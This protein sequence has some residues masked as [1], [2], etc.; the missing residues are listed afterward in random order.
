MANNNMRFNV[1]FNVDR[2]GLNAIKTE[3]QQIQNLS[4]Q[5]VIKAGGTQQAVNDLAKIKAHAQQLETALTKAFNPQLNT[6]NLKA[7]KQEL[8]NL[9]LNKLQQ[10]FYSL[11]T[12]GKNAFRSI[13]IDLL[14]Q[15]KYLKQSNTLLTKMRETMAN[16]VRWSITSTIINSITTSIRKAYSY[17]RDLDESLTNI[18]MVTEKSADSMKRFAKEANRAAKELG[19]STKAYTEASLIYYQQGLSDAEVKARTETTIKAANVTGQAAATVS[20]QLTA[21][22]NGY[23][24][25]TKETETYIDKLSAV[26]ASTAADL[27]ELSI[28]MSRVASAANIMGVD[29]DQLNAQLAT[30]VSVTREA[31]ESIGTALKTVYARMSDIEAGLDGET[32]LGEYTTEM[33][34]LGINALDSEGKLRN[35]GAVVE[36]IGNK[37]QSLTREQQTALAQTIAGTRQYSRMMALFDNWEMYEQAMSTS[38]NATGT[39]AAQQAIYMDSLEGRLHEMKAASE[40]VFDSLFDT[41]T[42][43]EIVDD[44][45]DLLEAVEY[46]ID[47][48]GGMKG[49]IMGVSA[50]LTGLFHGQIVSGL[51]QFANNIMGVRLNLENTALAMGMFVKSLDRTQDPRFAE[52]MRMEESLIANRKLLTKEEFAAGQELLSQ[53]ETLHRHTDELE[54]QK[55]KLQEQRA[56]LLDKEQTN[57]SKSVAASG[58]GMSVQFDSATGAIANLDQLSKALTTVSKDETELKN[59]ADIIG[60]AFNDLG[61]KTAGVKS[62]QDEYRE[63]VNKALTPMYELETSLRQIAQNMSAI[64]PKASQEI[65]ALA[66]SISKLESTGNNASAT[67]L[68]IYNRLKTL[69]GDQATSREKLLELLNQY[70]TKLDETNSKEKANNTELD[71]TEQKIKSISQVMDTIMKNMNMRA[72]L[73]QLVTSVTL[74]Q[75]LYF[76]VYSVI[77]LIENWNVDDGRSTFAKLMQFVVAFLPMIINI[78]STIKRMQVVTNEAAKKEAVA[79]KTAENEKQTAIKNTEITSTNTTSII[80]ANEKKV[81]TEA[82]KTAQAIKEQADAYNEVAAAASASQGART[83]GVA[84]S[85]GTSGSLAAINTTMPAGQKVY[86]PGWSPNQEARLANLTRLSTDTNHKKNWNSYT[87]EIAN[88]ETKK[89]QAYK[90]YM[91]TPVPASAPISESNTD[92]VKPLSSGNT[93]P[94]SGSGAKAMLSGIGMTV[95]ISAI[96]TLFTH[97]VSVVIDGFDKMAEQANRGQL[98][99]EATAQA[100]KHYNAELNTAISRQKDMAQDFDA[101]KEMQENLE[102]MTKGTEEYNKALQE[103]NAQVL[104]LVEKYSELSNYLTYE[105]GQY[106]IAEEGLRTAEAKQNNEIKEQASY[107]Q[108]SQMRQKQA[109]IDAVAREQGNAMNIRAWEESAHVGGAV[110]GTVGAS[111]GAIFGTV[112]GTAVTSAISAAASGA[113]AGAVAG[114]WGVVAGILVGLATATVTTIAAIHETQEE[115]ERLSVENQET[116]KEL[117]QKLKPSD[118]AAIMGANDEIT[119]TADEHFSER[120]SEVLKQMG[121]SDAEI[122]RLIKE[123]SENRGALKEVVDAYQQQR[124]M[125][126][127]WLSTAFNRSGEGGVYADALA[128]SYGLDAGELYLTAQSNIEDIYGQGSESNKGKTE[129]VALAYLKAIGKLDG[130]ATLADAKALYKL[131]ASERNFTITIDGQEQSLTKTDAMTV[132]IEEEMRALTQDIMHLVHTTTRELDIVFDKA[133]ISTDTRSQVV[134]ALATGTIIDFSDIAFDELV[135]LLQADQETELTLVDEIAGLLGDSNTSAKEA[136][137]AAAQAANQRFDRLLDYEQKMSANEYELYS[138]YIDGHDEIQSIFENQSSADAGAGADL[139]KTLQSISATGTVDEVAKQIQQVYAASGHAISEA[140][141]L[142]LALAAKRVQGTFDF[143]LKEEQASI[144]TL[145]SLF[146]K[147]NSETKISAN[148]YEKLT[149]KEKSYFSVMADGTAVLTTSA[150][151]FYRVVQEGREKEYQETR[152]SLLRSYKNAL[153]NIDTKAEEAET[154]AIKQQESEIDTK[155][156]AALDTSERNTNTAEMVDTKWDTALWDHWSEDGNGIQAFNA[157]IDKYVEYY[158]EALGDNTIT[159]DSVLKK[160]HMTDKDIG[161]LNSKS[162]VG[163]EQVRRLASYWELIEKN[164]D[165]MQGAAN[166]KLGI[167]DIAQQA[168]DNTKNQLLTEASKHIPDI[169]EL[170][171]SYA[172]EQ[173]GSSLSAYVSQQENLSDVFQGYNATTGK[174]DFG[175]GIKRTEAEL[176]EAGVDQV[177]IDAY[178]AGSQGILKTALY[179]DLNAINM[180]LESF[181]A[182]AGTDITQN[183][184][185]QIVGDIQAANDKIAGIKNLQALESVADSYDTIVSNLQQYTEYLSGDALTANIKEQNKLLEKQIDIWKSLIKQEETKIKA[186]KGTIDQKYWQDTDGD[187]KTSLEETPLAVIREQALRNNDTATV[188][189]IDRIWASETLIANYT[190]KIGSATQTTLENTIQGFDTQSTQRTDAENTLTDLERYEGSLSGA[191]LS[192]VLE[193]KNTQLGIIQ[194]AEQTRMDNASGYLKKLTNQ[195]ITETTTLDDL[196]EGV[197]D[198]E[199]INAI[200]LAWEDYIDAGDKVADT[201]K[202]ITDNTLAGIKALYDGVKDAKEE[203]LNDLQRVEGNLVGDELTANLGS[204]KTTLEDL[205]EVANENAKKGSDWLDKQFENSGID[206]TTKTLD[207]LTEGLDE[208][209]AANVTEYYNLWKDGSNDAA[210]YAQDIFNTNLKIFE[211]QLDQA[212]E[213][214]DKAAEYNEFVRSTLDEDETLK[215]ANTYAE[216]YVISMGKITTLQTELASLEDAGLSDADKKAKKEEIIAQLMTEAKNAKEAQ[217][218]IDNQILQTQEKITAEYEKQI[219][220]YQDKIDF[221]EK[222]MELT[223]LIY[224]ENSISFEAL[225]QNYLDQAE[226][227]KNQNALYSDSMNEQWEEMEKQ[228][229]I[230]NGVFKGTT[231]AAHAAWNRWYE[232]SKAQAENYIAIINKFREAWEALLDTQI[233]TAFKTLLGTSDFKLIQ[234]EWDWLNEQ[235][236]R[237]LDEYEKISQIASLSAKFDIEIANASLENKERFIKLQEEEK[238]RLEEISKLS[239]KDLAVSEKRL[240]LEKA[241]IALEQAQSNK[242][243]LRLVR[244]ADGTYTYQY[245]SD[246]TAIREAEEALRVAERELYTTT[247]S[248][249]QDTGKTIFTDVQNVFDLLRTYAL[250]DNGLTKEEIAGLTN[251]LGDLDKE[252]WMRVVEDFASTNQVFAGQSYEELMKNTEFLKYLEDNDIMPKSVMDMLNTLMGENVDL[253]TMFEAFANTDSKTAFEEYLTNNSGLNLSEEEIQVMLNAYDALGANADASILVSQSQLETLQSQ[254]QSLHDLNATLLGLDD[255]VALIANKIVGEGYTKTSYVWNDDKKVYEPAEAAT[256]ALL[257]EW[258]K[259]GRKMWVHQNELI[260]NAVDTNILLKTL[261]IV[262]SQMAHN[263]GATQASMLNGLSLSEAVWELAKEMQIEQNIN[264]QANFPN[265]KDKNEIEAAFKELVG[266]AIQHA[267]KTTYA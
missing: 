108:M 158:R 29:I 209:T 4:A 10:E 263:V 267:F 245:T 132:L 228:G 160:L 96:I 212:L 142:E 74:T 239:E 116:Y 143:D 213:P 47:S 40:G 166:L 229:W 238:K 183:E 45:T 49:V 211:E 14:T 113:A 33:A 15:N 172:R 111:A 215:L 145:N 182:L 136:L 67:T 202:E 257:P 227:L 70:N 141:A 129:K 73:S 214:L 151:E 31:P 51:A 222:E 232:T 54:L 233:E 147:L 159:R 234:D 12:S 85:L 217:K 261:D 126:K 25:T 258:G 176:I 133:Q 201:T 24:V 218:A 187:G 264:I 5:S 152:A 190:G 249:L 94:P 225:E 162:R 157:T 179:A 125:G 161:A 120:V 149:L 221:I 35:M 251:R 124:D 65:F 91:P 256:G 110:I 122:D 66:D 189:A 235:N 205:Q 16:T 57:I 195:D 167:K 13:T 46:V 9:N 260:L 191:A 156:K 11:G 58:I 216:D 3:L 208:E 48:F 79:T 27:E 197:T 200:T 241:K 150:A 104:A 254:L 194:A 77:N 153:D 36:E 8:S 6:V 69:L 95:A 203:T 17:V 171:L 37:W 18:M 53:L 177:T 224:G 106:Q 80:V 101:Y 231:E 128:Y 169:M 61:E 72:F 181:N 39:L 255:T 137:Y 41:E 105:N 165:E 185:G 146:E 107:L 252:S 89:L 114:P 230:V 135:Q 163:Y 226:F 247:K 174:F 246:P 34:K 186:E 193:A 1:S 64:N 192:A 118:F 87:T 262:K 220:F 88:L 259:E 134:K 265:A 198:E 50:A 199:T 140:Y 20:E 44:L 86:P 144:A 168:Y 148:E 250:D 23:K 93:P 236:S 60:Q 97:L 242:N 223:R 38:L 43:K 59:A 68:E 21:V 62:K 184:A 131:D 99:I 123:L 82:R 253:N 210:Q 102:N 75:Q 266:L 244:G 78:I 204:Q 71:A 121:K 207:E 103:S 28:G 180:S 175:D 83:A 119:Q 55:Q 19:A 130:S 196:L 139:I 98:E 112:A 206:W 237:Y 22:W 248:N 138:Q 92:G 26:A 2:S 100:V 7:F 109:R 117:A 81:A 243:S 219:N 42:I 178:K 30:I 154:E 52:M 155:V 115:L 84:T 127:G 76:S 240:A 56:L 32:S 90:S 173:G 164:M 188:A 63:A 170:D